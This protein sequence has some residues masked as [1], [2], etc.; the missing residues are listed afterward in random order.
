MS[1]KTPQKQFDFAEFHSKTRPLDIDKL[2]LDSIGKV[3]LEDEELFALHYMYDIEGSIAV[4]L[5]NALVSKM[6]FDEEF[7]NFSLDWAVEENSHRDALRT[8]LEIYHQKQPG[9]VPELTLR[10]NRLP[11]SQRFGWLLM[12]LFG[13]IAPNLFRASYASI[14]TVNELLTGGGGYRLGGQK[15]NC[16]VLCEL[17][18]CLKKYEFRHATAYRQIATD[19]LQGRLGLQKMN[20]LVVKK[21]WSMVG[22]GIRQ[23][24]D[25]MRVAKYFCQ[26][27]SD[28][29]YLARLD[30]Q[31]GRIPGL[32]HLGLL[33]GLAVQAGYHAAQ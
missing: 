12:G 18:A 1:K 6:A 10:S 32:E 16:P 30:K 3:K 21:F 31:I 13:N 26:N 11:F 24:T 19:Q 28:Y 8:Y 17:F 22:V 23:Q 2:D 33:Q 25:G 15:T 29:E 27:Q 20:R 7:V 9:S 4:Y 14:G 5:R